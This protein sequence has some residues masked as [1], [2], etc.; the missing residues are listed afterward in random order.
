[1]WTVPKDWTHGPSLRGVLKTRSCSGLDLWI[2][3]GW[4][5]KNK[6]VFRIGLMDRP[7][8]EPLKQGVVPDWTRELSTHGA[9]KTRR[10]SGLDS[11]IVPAWSLKNKEVFRI[12]LVDRPHVEPYKKGG[13]PDWTR[14]SSLR[15][16]LKTRRCSGLDSW[17]IP[18]FCSRSPCIE[19]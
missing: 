8:V 7:C 12:G 3:P 18:A 9:L 16:A 4:S 11:W 15:G 10:C 17:I 6:E 2:V 19:P 1:M 5:L 14:G 13:V